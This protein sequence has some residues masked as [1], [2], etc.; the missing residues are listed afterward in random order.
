MT[1][2]GTAI[3]QFLRGHIFD[4]YRADKEPLNKSSIVPTRLPTQRF[5]R[6]YPKVGDDA[7]LLQILAEYSLGW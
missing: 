7:K 4:A 2:T 6:T 1:T 3:W 5:T